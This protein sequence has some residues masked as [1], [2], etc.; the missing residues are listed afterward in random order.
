MRLH[1]RLQRLAGHGTMF[2]LY[3]YD[4]AKDTAR[5]NIGDKAFSAPKPWKS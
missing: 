2:D 1:A 3:G 5:I 4:Q